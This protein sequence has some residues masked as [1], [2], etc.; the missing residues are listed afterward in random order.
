MKINLLALHL[1]AI[2]KITHSVFRNKANHL[3]VEKEL[4]TA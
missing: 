3:K 1:N 2:I 4:R